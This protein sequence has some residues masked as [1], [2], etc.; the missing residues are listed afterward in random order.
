MSNSDQISSLQNQINS[1]WAVA[2]L[3]PATKIEIAAIGD[4]TPH[5]EVVG[6][7]FEIVIEERGVEIDRY[8]QLT[9]IEATRWYIHQMAFK[10]S[11]KMELKSR[12]RQTSNQTSDH[13]SADSGY[14]RWNWIAPTIATMT[15]ILPDFGFWAHNYY[16]A[17]LAESPLKEYEI[18]NARYPVF[19]L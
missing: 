15:D 9:I 2:E 11:L 16:R 12:T 3:G 10:H 17:I 6:G 4:A 18:R 5:V 1:L 19:E 7:F 13:F 14:S 8:R